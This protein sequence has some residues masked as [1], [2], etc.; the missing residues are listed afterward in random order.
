MK[1]KLIKLG[2][3]AERHEIKEIFCIESKRPLSH[4]DCFIIKELDNCQLPIAVFP[5]QTAYGRE[6]VQFY[7]ELFVEL[8]NAHLKRQSK[9][10][11]RKS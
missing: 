4:D 5:Y 9:I 10:R 11:N 2:R 3:D 1:T 8:H 6:H 7:A